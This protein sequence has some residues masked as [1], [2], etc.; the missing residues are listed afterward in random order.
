MKLFLRIWLLLLSAAIF[1]A[2]GGG[3]SDS[4]PS[5]TPSDDTGNNDGGDPTDDG[6]TTQDIVR[7]GSFSSGTFTPG[8]IAANKTSLEA[9]QSATLTVSFIDQNNS[10]VTDAASVLFTSSC[11]GSGLSEAAPSIVDN[12]TG[13]LTTTYT[14][15]GCDGDDTITAQT[16]LDG[17]TFSA[18][19]DITTVQA[20]LGSVSFTEASLSNIGI[21]G[22]GAI[23]EQAVVSFLVTNSSGGP[24][25]NQD[26]T[27][28][29]NN[30]TGGI[31]LS[32]TT[33]TTD[34]NG[35]ASTTVAA[36]T[37]ATSVRVTATATRDGI[38]ST[39]QSSQLAIT[40]G[41]PDDD[42]FSLSA[43]ELNIEGLRIDG[44]TTIL[45][46]R[47]A[48]RYNNPVPNDTAITFQAEGGSIESSCLTTAGA[49]SVT[50]TSQ[51]PRPA[52]GR[53][54]V[55]ATA[56][57][58]ETFVD[59]SPSNGRYDDAET[60]TDRAE[61]FR[62]DNE[63]G[64]R[65]ADE[66][67]IDFNNND[68]FDAA[69]GLYEGV[70]CNGPGNCNQAQTTITMRESIV[71]V[72]SGSSLFVNASPSV[73]NLDSGI[74]PVTVT[75]TDV[76]GQVPAAGTTISV[77]TSQ[78]TIEGVSSETQLSTS[79]NGPSTFFFRVKPADTPGNGTFSIT[80]TSPSGVISRE[81]SDVI[82]TVAL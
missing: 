31:S 28:S 16:S 73:I 81:F 41:I 50:L 30:T 52:N 39:A 68:Q 37:V 58:E 45:T 26:V 5:L 61:A 66:T 57:G 64:L 63:N 7:F 13:T 71:I 23:P 4:D 76:N 25:P 62:D 22:S 65:D 15:R 82:Q 14:A 20:P 75:V 3:G 24:V 80:V 72:L 59:S 51:D 49:C 47:A 32:N 70:L 46:L 17:T 21:K 48:D 55:L 12:T 34:A 54:T 56:I 78:G 8:R 44:V 19:I 38:T 79:D 74:V 29:L 69:S 40:T 2:C 33:D 36:G 53:I 77:E 9:G 1:T 67:Y 60:F 42:S 10:P 27:F 35:I 18:T 11:I 6:S 43:S